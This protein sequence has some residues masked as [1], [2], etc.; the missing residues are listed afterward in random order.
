MIFRG[1]YENALGTL[2][3]IHTD[4][5][6]PRE[7]IQKLT[8]QGVAHTHLQQFAKANEE[9]VAASRI[10]DSRIYK[11][12][13]DL[14]RARGMAA[15]ERGEFTGARELFLRN[16]NFAREQRDE[17]MDA[18]ALVNLGFVSLGEQHYDEALD[19]LGRAR[20]ATIELHAEDLEERTSG[21]IGWAYLELG[22]LDRARE[23]F[24]EAEQIA[25]KVGNVREQLKWI[26]AQGVGDQISENF[27]KAFESYRK[28]LALARTIDSKED[29]VNSLE[30][31]AHASVQNRKLDEAEEYLQLVDPL[32]RANGNRLDALDVMLARGRIAAARRQ[33]EQAESLFRQVDSDPASQITMRLGA[34]HELAR[35]FEAEGRPDDARKEYVTAL[36]TFE[37]ARA[38]I[39]NEDSKL[40]YFANATPIYDDYI[41]LLI[42]QGKTEDA[43]A[44]ADQSRA[45][46]L[47]Q[48][49]GLV[50]DKGYA[51][52]SALR[53]GLIAARAGAG[54]PATLLFYWLGEK[55]SWLW[56]ITPRK[57]SVFPL[58][59]KAEI[60]RMVE[61][62]RREL[63]GPE[64]PLRAENG[65]GN[66][67]GLALYR[68]LV[69]PAKDLIAPGGKVVVLC[70]GD[71]SKLN[72]ETLLVAGAAPQ[73][74]P[75]YWIEDAEVVSAPSLRMV[76][77]AG[78]E[79][80]HPG[81]AKSGRDQNGAPGR[82]LLVG[83]AVSPSPDYPEL[84]NAPVEMREIEKHFAPQ[85]ATV[86]ARG[87]ANA[88]AYLGSE[89]RRFAYIDFVAHGVAS[90]TDPLDSAIILSRTQ[91]GT[92]VGTQA[93]EDSFKL[94]AR[95][96]MRHPIDAR[97]VTIAACYGGGTRSYAG[98]GLVGLSWAFLRAGAHNVIGALWEVSDASAPKL[99]D[100]LYQG[101]QDGMTPSAALR[102]AKLKLLHG[103][104]T[105]GGEFRRPF[106][107]GSFQLY[108]D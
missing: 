18:G 42:A 62:Y 75:H 108:S 28:A 25:A 4:S 93:G 100:S 57:T 65:R 105:D 41:R 54:T 64:D 84:P 45:R 39:K 61:R 3:E 80:T 37:S 35:L 66:P 43:L 21:N 48:G 51:K 82:L 59:A 36:G 86:F 6:E 94:Y 103:T 22:D 55:Q 79:G 38:A 78:F 90:R 50:G 53:P 98:E 85:E 107:W 83:D 67:D 32:I 92:H 106:Y 46:T 10:C 33:D 30:D 7:S 44:A 69:S 14:L 34:E 11:E 9:L 81:R 73:D 74:R 101:L 12:C 76:G 68:M 47:E 20:Q 5:S 40:P 17:W 71:L 70:D 15:M 89:P 16:L 72:F 8:L 52:E 63:L 88:A 95:E 77:R 23:Y 60:A 99:M 58:P 27:E 87:R 29:I 31:L 96:I 97:L 1:F 102:A 56:A 2:S 104:G 26:T 24:V 49:L 13:G 19:W 91:A